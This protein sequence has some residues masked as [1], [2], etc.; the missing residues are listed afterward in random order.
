M[1][2]PDNAIV[3]CVDERPSIQDLERAQGYLK[4]PNGGALTGHSR[5]YKRHGTST[6][7]AA[8]A[9]PTSKVT[10]AHKPRRRRIAFLAFIHDSVIPCPGTGEARLA[11]DGTANPHTHR[12][13]LL[14]F[15]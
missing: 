14:S 5:D 15:P 4:L 3:I 1:A 2:P 10:A 7:F 8:F 11:R 6:L 9:M 12:V 13:A